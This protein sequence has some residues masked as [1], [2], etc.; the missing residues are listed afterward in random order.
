M[1]WES[2]YSL[3][4]SCE[5][6][7]IS[8]LVYT[9]RYLKIRRNALPNSIHLPDETFLNNI[10]SKHFK[11]VRKWINCS[12]DCRCPGTLRRCEQSTFRMQKKLKHNA[13]KP[14]P[15]TVLLQQ[16][17]NQKH[18]KTYEKHS[19]LGSSKTT[20]RISLKEKLLQKR[21]MKSVG[22]DRRV[23]LLEV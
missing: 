11:T 21:K 5:E 23:R 16:K 17:D 6:K 1:R 10:F 12:W 14:I 18:P 3:L 22:E 2:F 9:S 15:R 8:I 7:I 20:H 13:R 19:I 4:A